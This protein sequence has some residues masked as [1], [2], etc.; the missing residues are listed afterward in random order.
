V[1]GD[2]AG[3]GGCNEGFLRDDSLLIIVIL[4]DE[5]DG[6]VNSPLGQYDSKS[7]GDAPDWYDTVV[8]ARGGIESNV[9]VLSLIQWLPDGDCDIDNKRD[10]GHVIKEFTEMFTHGFVGRICDD[11]GPYFTEA[12]SVIDVACDEYV[13]PEG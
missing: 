13:P 11:F 2:L 9:V 6:P 5:S 8:N 12:L 1:R 4:T 10:D 3:P 7:G